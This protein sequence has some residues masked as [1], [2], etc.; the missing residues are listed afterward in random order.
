MDGE[1]VGPWIGCAVAPAIMILSIPLDALALSL[2]WNWF[3][4]P[5]LNV[6]TLGMG[7]AIGIRILIHAL[8]HSREH[9]YRTDADKFTKRQF[10]R[11][12]GDAIGY[13]IITIAMAFV[14]HLVMS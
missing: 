1:E 7:A 6:P 9:I 14:W 12:A 8:W 11:A 10:A 3:L 2:C 5:V 4:V 13:P